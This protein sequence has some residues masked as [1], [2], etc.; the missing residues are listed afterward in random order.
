MIELENELFE[1]V[2][3]IELPRK[4][5]EKKFLKVSNKIYYTTEKLKVNQGFFIPKD[6]FNCAPKSI[7][8]VVLTPLNKLKNFYKSNNIEFEF[9]T[10]LRK[11]E[12]KNILGIVI[13]RVI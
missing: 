11:D 8:R 4:K 3:N 5:Q 9:K 13:K 10:S 6:E 7:S 1:I 2:D 12:N